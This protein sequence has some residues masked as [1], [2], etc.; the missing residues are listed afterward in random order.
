M[1]L[2]LEVQADRYEVEQSLLQ[3][4][5]EEVRENFYENRMK[6]QPRQMNEWERVSLKSF[7]EQV[8]NS[9]KNH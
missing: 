6:R 7:N 1:Y 5:A 4:M 2:D 9:F 3:E 8:M